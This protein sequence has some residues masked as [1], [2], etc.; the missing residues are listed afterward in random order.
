[1]NKNEK[2][3]NLRAGISV[4]SE[5]IKFLLQNIILKSEN[6]VETEV[7]AGLALDEINRISRMSEK[8][9]IILKH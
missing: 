4:K 7:F 5:R 8:I 1:M 9:G 6:T 2:L 3:Y